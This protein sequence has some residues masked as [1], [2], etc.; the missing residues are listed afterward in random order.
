MNRAERS[1]LSDGESGSSDMSSQ[2]RPFAGQWAH[3]IAQ[4]R[5]FDRRHGHQKEIELLSEA[6]RIGNG[7]GSIVFQLL[8]SG[9][10]KSAAAPPIP[11]LTAP[12]FHHSGSGNRTT[13]LG[14]HRTG[15]DWA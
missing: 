4:R 9:I 6:F 3:G 14:D 8:S 15:I 7:Y 13:K 10:P 11:P 1:E 12:A 5:R 2:K